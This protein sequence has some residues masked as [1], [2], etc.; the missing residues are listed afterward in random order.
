MKRK[1]LLN[2]S[3]AFS[4]LLFACGSSESQNKQD[5]LISGQLS[6]MANQQ[7]YLLDLSQPKAGPVDT[8][9]V[10]EAGNF[11]FDYS[12]SKIGFYRVNLNQNMALILP[13]KANDQITV[14]GQASDANSLEVKG[15]A[16]AERMTEFNRF[17]SSAMEEQ[18]QLNAEFQQYANHP[19]KDS[20]LTA[21]QKKYQDIESGIEDKIKTMIDQDA[22]LFSNLALMEQL[23]P[24]NADNIPYFKKVEKALADQYSQSPFYQNF[25]SKVADAGRFAPGTEVP[26]INLP[27]PDGK[28]VPLSSLKGKVVLIDFWASWCK[29]CRKENPNVVAAYQKYKDKGFT[30]YGVSLDRTKEAWVNAIKNDGLSWTHVSDLK[31]WQ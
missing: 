16:D 11:G 23:S 21:F 4:T 20:I 6:D 28:M 1:T 27:N 31:F 22:S 29:P 25:K 12:P 17:L 19:K 10:D 9:F 13:L 2:L 8:A 7:L 3:L 14:N 15:S 30:V 24:E 18:Q 5:Y 26:E